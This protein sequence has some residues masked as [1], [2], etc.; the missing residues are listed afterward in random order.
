MLMCGPVST[1]E[2]HSSRYVILSPLSKMTDKERGDRIRDLALLFS[3]DA[4]EINRLVPAGGLAISEG[5]G[6][7]VG[8]AK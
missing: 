6:V 4:D 2:K 5:K 1:L 7:A 3:T 8:A